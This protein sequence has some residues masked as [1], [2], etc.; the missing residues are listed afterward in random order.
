MHI[1]VHTAAVKGSELHLLVDGQESATVPAK[2]IESD[3]AYQDETI[4]A[5]AGRHWLRIE[6]R[7]SE[8]LLQLTSSPV[9]INFPEE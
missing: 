9:Y 4:P 6:V 3:S 7:D 5:S 2:R 1:R 8:G